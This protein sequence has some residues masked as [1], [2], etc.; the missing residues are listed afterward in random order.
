MHVVFEKVPHVLE[1]FFAK[2]GRGERF[3]FRFVFSH[4]TLVIQVPVTGIGLTR[5]PHQRPFRAHVTHLI[6]VELP[7][8]L[9]FLQIEFR[10]FY[11]FF[12][13]AF[14]GV[15]QRTRPTV[16][17]RHVQLFR[18]LLNG[19]GQRLDLL[20]PLLFLPSV[21]LP[22]DP[23]QRVFLDELRPRVVIFIIT[24]LQLV[25]LAVVETG[26]GGHRGLR[27]RVLPRRNTGVCGRSR[28]SRDEK[29]RKE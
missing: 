18:P 15:T 14:L 8:A 4:E 24:Q 13:R 29:K 19:F 9:C 7:F 25:P 2:R 12:D 27:N 21:R 20:T 11:C 26:R 23:P 22:F 17:V 10:V 5:V 3:E 6:R 1:A 28:S 16:S